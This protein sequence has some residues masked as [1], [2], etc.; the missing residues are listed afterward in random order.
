M[1]A[2]ETFLVPE[3][4]DHLWAVI[5]DPLLDESSVV[6]ICLLSWREYHD[7]AC[8]LDAGDHP[9]IK[10]ST[11]VNYP[12]TRIETNTL[13]ERLKTDGKL[14]AEGNRCRSRC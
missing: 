11:C 14:E 5:S 4:D 2:G 3:L 1:L 10:R 6:I 13:L 7:Q 8:V 9:F 12:G